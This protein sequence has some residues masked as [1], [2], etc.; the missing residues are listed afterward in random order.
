MC[1]DTESFD[2]QA[3]FPVVRGCPHC[4]RKYEEM[5]QKGAGDLSSGSKNGLSATSS[6]IGTDLDAL[7]DRSR[8]D[9]GERKWKSQT[10]SKDREAAKSARTSVVA[11][12]LASI[13]NELGKDAPLWACKQLFIT[14]QALGSAAF[15]AAEPGRGAQVEAVT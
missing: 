10:G 13:Q 12:S 11:P 14:Q 3:D 6:T 4:K 15:A 9:R 5:E 7:S 2:S 1:S 8:S